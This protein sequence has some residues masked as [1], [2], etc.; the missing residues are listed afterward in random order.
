MEIEQVPLNP[1]KFDEKF[2][3]EFD[4]TQEGVIVSDMIRYNHPPVSPTDGFIHSVVSSGG[5]Y[6][7]TAPLP[8]FKSTNNNDIQFKITEKYFLNPLEL[9]LEGVIVNPH[10]YQIAID[11]SFHSLIEKITVYDNSGKLIEQIKD[12]PQ[13]TSL[14][15]EET[16][17]R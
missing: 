17:S 8:E 5:R 1:C 2:L 6:I 16:L 3:Q 9:Y 11:D 13:I 10:G 4:V 14:Y 7:G 15:F 12:Y